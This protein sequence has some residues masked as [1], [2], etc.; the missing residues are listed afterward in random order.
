MGRYVCSYL[1]RPS[2]L[3]SPLIN[4]RSIRM[5]NAHLHRAKVPEATMQRQAKHEDY[6]DTHSMEWQPCGCMIDR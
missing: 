4:G 6:R 1:N 5:Q 3:A 2:G